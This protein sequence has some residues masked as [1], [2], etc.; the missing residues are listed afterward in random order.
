M[1]I[2]T[3]LSLLEA[4]KLFPNYSINSLQKSVSGVVDT[5]YI[6]EKYII[7]KYEREVNI[8]FDN[9]LLAYLHTNGLNVP[10][11][12]QSS[13][14]WHLY[15]KLEGKEVKSVKL[16]HI[17]SLARFMA[18]FHSLTKEYDPK[19]DFLQSYK[20]D[21]K[22]LF[23]KKLSFC[24]YKKLQHLQN[25]SPNNDGFIHG[26]LFKDNALFECNKIKVFDFIDGAMGNFC[27][28]CAVALV[29]FDRRKL[30]VHTFLKSYNQHAPKKISK[31]ELL[32]MMNVASHF[33]ALLRV[34]HYKNRKKA[35]E[36]L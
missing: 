22:L 36:L 11:H 24:T 4:Q 3:S 31:K 14:D 6:S 27:F 26:D 1:G 17:H 32:A 19:K 25:F 33:Y 23:A 34:A 20:V 18:K 16:F 8:A 15:S 29:G 12:L 9:K 21:E 13:G 7:K 28:D 30:Y 2:K 5:T 35:K 10:Q